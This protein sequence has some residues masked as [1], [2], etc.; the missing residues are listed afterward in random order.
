MDRYIGL[1]AH[2]SSCTVATIGPSGGRLQSQVVETNAKALI[3]V[4][5]LSGSVT[6]VLPVFVPSLALTSDAME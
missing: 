3:Q 2:S 1:D 4:I 5:E 6:L